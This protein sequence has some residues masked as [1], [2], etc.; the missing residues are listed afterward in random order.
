MW[1]S[2]VC[3]CFIKHY[4]CII[5]SYARAQCVGMWSQQTASCEKRQGRQSGTYITNNIHPCLITAHQPHRETNHRWHSHSHSWRIWSCQSAK[6][7]LSLHC[8]EGY[9]LRRN[10]DRRR[11]WEDT[12]PRR[13]LL[14]TQSNW[15]GRKAGT[16]MQELVRPNG[17]HT[18]YILH[19]FRSGY[20]IMSISP[21]VR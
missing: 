12:T 14:K 21:K 6:Y 9:L 8:G 16:A 3:S 20:A 2:T 13:G 4:E 18:L 15:G 19:I 5:M 11:K 7:A 1:L 10:A 17:V